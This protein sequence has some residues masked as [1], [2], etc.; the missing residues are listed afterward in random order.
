[1]YNKRLP[2]LFAIQLTFNC[3]WVRELHFNTKCS[4][5]PVTLNNSSDYWSNGLMD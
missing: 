3:T 2:F 1:M 5:I 4:K